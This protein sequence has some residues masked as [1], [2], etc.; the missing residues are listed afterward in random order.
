MRF[1]S[2][3]WKWGR[4]IPSICHVILASNM[5]SLLHRFTSFMSI[6]FMTWPNGKCFISTANEL[7]NPQDSANSESNSRLKSCKP[8]HRGMRRRRCQ[9][10]GSSELQG[11]ERQRWVSMALR[12][13]E[14]R[15]AA[16]ATWPEL[17]PS[18]P[19]WPS[20]SWLRSLVAEPSQCFV[21]R[22]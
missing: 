19:C 1:S 13:F 14:E 20:P 7:K 17:R 4:V 10:S 12:W 8:T 21:P 22:Q 3:Y 15:W 9:S 16:W 18:P 11:E 5:R 6:C 2:H